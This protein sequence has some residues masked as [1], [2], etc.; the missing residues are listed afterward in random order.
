MHGTKIYLRSDKVLVQTNDG[1]DSYET[2]CEG[3]FFSLN[4]GEVHSPKV[5]KSDQI[6]SKGTHIRI[7]GYNNNQRSTLKQDILK[8]YL[9]WYTILGTIENQFPN[10]QL[11]EFKVFLQALDRDEPELLCSGHPF[12]KENYN[13]NKLFDTYGEIAV[14]YYVKKYVYAEQSLE[15]M[16]EVKYD[17]VIYFEG[18]EAKRAYNPMIRERRNNSSGR[19]KVSD[20]YGLLHGFINCQKLISIYISMML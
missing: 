8:D 12:P 18:D 7:E 2:E 20:R 13:I 19:Y 4:A 3:A 9:Y 14:D 16:P 11:R 15:T 6:F 1:I 5:R 17:V 10:R